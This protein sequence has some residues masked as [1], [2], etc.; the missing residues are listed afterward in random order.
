MM[1]VQSGEVRVEIRPR[2]MEEHIDG[3]LFGSVVVDRTLVGD[4]RMDGYS[5]WTDLNTTDD[6]NWYMGATRNTDKPVDE[7]MVMRWLHRSG[8]KPL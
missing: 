1:V 7:P 5:C 8:P 4:G 2:P 6:E 3:K